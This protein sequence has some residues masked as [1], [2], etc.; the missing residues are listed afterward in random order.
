M[1]LMMGSGQRS[2]R[3]VCTSPT[4]ERVNSAYFKVLLRKTLDAA[5]AAESGQQP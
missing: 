5:P 3:S 2:P 1:A 4:I